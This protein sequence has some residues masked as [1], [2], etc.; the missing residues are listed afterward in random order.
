MIEIGPDSVL[1]R[2]EQQFI[3][4]PVGDE[5]IILDLA[6]GDYLGLNTVGAFIWS[7]LQQPRTVSQIIDKLMAT[8]DVDRETC[9]SQTVDYIGR[10]NQFGLIRESD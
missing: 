9:T 7:E 6:T 5:V 8:Y 3:S 10:M 2:N 1:T 4:N